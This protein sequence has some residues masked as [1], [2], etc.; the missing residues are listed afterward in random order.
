MY[1]ALEALFL[2]N[3]SAFFLNSLFYLLIV[4]NITNVALKQASQNTD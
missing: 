3:C 1:I 2:K 4:M